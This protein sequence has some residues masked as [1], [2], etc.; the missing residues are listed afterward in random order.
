MSNERSREK[1]CRDLRDDCTL[2]TLWS[3]MHSFILACATNDACE[4][5]I[6]PLQDSRAPVHD[7]CTRIRTHVHAAHIADAPL[8]EQRT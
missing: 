4:H 7:A 1:R 3:L 8:R 2:G 5:Y 6:Y